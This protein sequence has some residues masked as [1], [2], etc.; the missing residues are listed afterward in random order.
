MEGNPRHWHCI[1]SCWSE[2]CTGLFAM[3]GEPAPCVDED[4]SQEEE[5][6]QIKS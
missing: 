2:N 5:A 1:T 3:R 6:R 4:V